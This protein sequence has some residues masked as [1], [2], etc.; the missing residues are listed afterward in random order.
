MARPPGKPPEG[1]G[2]A[3]PPAAGPAA[4][5]PAVPAAGRAGRLL[6]PRGE[7]GQ[8][9]TNT[10]LFF[11]LVYV[12]AITQ[13]AH[14][15]LGQLSL[16]GAAQT[17]LLLLAVWWAWVDTAW[18][19]NWFH[20]DHRAVR[21]LLLATML[22]SLVMSIAL[23]EAFGSR[24]LIFAAAYV[25]IQLGRSL[26]AVAALGSHPGLRRNFQRILAWAAAA[27]ALWIAGGLVSGAAR[28]WLWVAAAAADSCRPA[29]G[30]PVPGLGRSRTSD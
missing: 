27:G 18:I 26:F 19:T 30:F 29:V 20:P 28:D 13:L 8:S 10:E 24:G 15:L 16:R 11:D 7:R 2:P 25:T 4:R 17:A 3:A 22:V 5:S 9:V 23:P 14:L 6:R 12:F 21:A 1:A